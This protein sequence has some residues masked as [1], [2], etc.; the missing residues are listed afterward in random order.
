MFKQILKLNTRRF[1]K[2]IIIKNQLRFYSNGAINNKGNT[3]TVNYSLILSVGLISGISGYFISQ[4]S[5]SNENS[6]EIITDRSTTKLKDLKTPIYA[7]P[8]ELVQGLIE[9]KNLLPASC[10]SNSESEINS[11]ASDPIKFVPPMDNERSDI[12]VY[13]ETIEQ[14]SEI[15]KICHKYRIP[16]IPYSG[17]TSIEGHYIPTRRGVCI[18]MSKMNKILAVHEDDLDVVVQPG[19]GWMELNEELDHYGLMFGCDPGPGAEIGGM[20]ATSCSGTNAS[21]YGTMKENV[22]SLKVVLADGTIIKTKNRP[23]K[24]SNGYNLTGLFVGSEGTLGIIV[25]ATLKLHVKPRHEIVALMHFKQIRDAT[26]T[27]SDIFKSGLLVN[28]VELMDEKQMTA[29]AETGAG[30]DR[31]FSPNHMLLFKLGGISEESVN[32]ITKIV[33]EISR[34]NNGFNFQVAK[35]DEDKEDIWR[36]RKTLLW[37][38]LNWAKERMPNV[39][40]LPTDVAVPVSKLPEMIES[41][42]IEIEEKGLLGTAA[43]HAGDGNVHV[44]V[45]FPPEKLAIAKQVIDN[46]CNKA[47]QLE[48]MISGEHG[49]GAGKREF[50]MLELGEETI[51][52]MRS[53]KLSLDPLRLLNP[54][55]IFA[56]DPLENRSH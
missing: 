21:R 47:I 20:V 22:I 30:G 10:I 4:K 17:G 41:T 14:V 19:I 27:V 33:D 12:I 37:N 23:R 43:G 9:I 56:I 5:N 53:I 42:M 52:T 6:N 34:K 26:K 36:I 38:S 49:I 48:G 44:L 28:A 13:P 39:K 31:K 25:E 45:I 54:D 24:S 11:H 15:A 55:K 16:M 32:E 18:D 1:P 46:M 29:I 7:T 40:V 8:E 3:S 51:N 2:R 35:D 50:L